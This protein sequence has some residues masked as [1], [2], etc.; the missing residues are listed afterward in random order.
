MLHRGF[1]PIF[2]EG[3]EGDFGTVAKCHRCWMIQSYEIDIYAFHGS[4]SSRPPA[5]PAFPSFPVLHQPHLGADSRVAAENLIGGKPG[6]LFTH[7][8]L[9]RSSCSIFRYQPMW[10]SCL[11][12][13]EEL[14]SIALFVAPIWMD[15]V[16]Q[17]FVSLL[18]CWM[19]HVHLGFCLI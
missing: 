14:N 15:C 17:Y 6:E 2:F 1:V 4:F 10:I 16:L 8:N 7:R 5:R 19:A 11:L 12:C 9:E 18:C 3:F 13:G